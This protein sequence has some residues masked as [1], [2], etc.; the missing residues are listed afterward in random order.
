MVECHQ[1][2]DRAKVVELSTDHEQLA[3]GFSTNRPEANSGQHH[4]LSP[5][6]KTEVLEGQRSPG[7]PG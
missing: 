5:N 3:S 1:G 7:R 2:H 6:T 4:H